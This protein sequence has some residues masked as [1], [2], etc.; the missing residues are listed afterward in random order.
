MAIHVRPSRQ[1]QQLGALVIGDHQLDFGPPSFRH[2]SLDHE[3]D[4]FATESVSG[5]LVQ[6]RRHHEYV[7]VGRRPRHRAH[8]VGAPR[9]ERGERSRLSSTSSAP[10]VAPSSRPSPS[11]CR[12]R[13]SRPS[14]R[15]RPKPQLIFDRFPRA[16]PRTR[17]PRPGTS[18]RGAR[19]RRRGQAGAQE[20]ALGAAQ[21]PLEPLARRARKAVDL[22]RRQQAPLPCLLAQRGARRRPRLPTDQRGNP[23][24]RRVDLMGPDAR[25]S[26]PFKKLAET[27]RK[28]TTGILAY[29]SSGLSNGRTEALNGKA[30]TTWAIG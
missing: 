9:Q 23:Q 29:V 26:A 15:P 25:V 20:D 24:A 27:I 22:A 3:R 6:Y 10:S 13:T 30:R 2:V 18:R 14:P 28:H 12:P 17:R 21:E 4:S 8:R 16:A 1:A 5:G 19:G 11:T 7:T